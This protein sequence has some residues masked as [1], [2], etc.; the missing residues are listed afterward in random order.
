MSNTFPRVICIGAATLDAIVVADVPLPVDARI[1]VEQ[2]GV[3][4]GGPAATA[5]VA[6]ARQ[7]ISVAFAG[8]VGDDEAG[9]MVVSS[10]E[11]EGVDTRLVQITDGALTAFSAIVVDRATAD[12]L[13]LTRPG[14]LPPVDPRRELLAAVADA[15]WLHL[16]QAGWAVWRAL[17][18]RLRARGSTSGD[19]PLLSVDGGNPIPG[20]EL[21]G[22]ALYAPS[23]AGLRA[24]S[25]KH[26]LDA[27]MRWALDAGAA[28]VVVTRGRSGS[29]AMARFDL[30]RPGAE[31]A[32][33]GGI[34]PDASIQRI[35]EPGHRFEVVSTLGAG[36]VFH[37]LLLAGIREGRSVRDA[38]RR[39]NVGAAVSCRGIDGRSAIPGQ[40]ELETAMR[41]VGTKTASVA[42]GRERRA[43]DAIGAAF[44]TL[45]RPSETFA[46]VAIDQRESLRAMLAA[47]DDPGLILDEALVGF[48]R[49]VMAALGSRASAILL[50]RPLGLP[51]LESLAAP[52]AC[53]LILAADVLDQSPGGPIRR[54]TLDREAPVAAQRIGAVA[55]KML[56]PWRPSESPADRAALVE[57]FTA[58]CRKAG[59]LALVE[60]LVSDDGT[61]S[62]EWNG[63]EGILAAAEEMAG[64]DFDLY[65]A[66]VPT[67]GRGEAQTIR[68]LAARITATIGRPWVVLS[69]GVP[70]E[71]FEHG[72]RAACMGGASGFLAGR[73]IWTSALDAADRLSHLADVSAGRLERLGDL[74]D[75]LGRSWEAAR[76]RDTTYPAR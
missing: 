6:I 36:D 7:G 26:D 21:A 11:R 8:R 31:D 25:G 75:T 44:H 17:A 48:K 46:M 3:A 74:V 38:M 27:A 10:L 5:A 61:R 29:V 22:V 73:A 28:L 20:L 76:S 9:R 13:I 19:G 37:G 45:A 54:V 64:L 70:A 59:L 42:V 51:A 49:E 41:D 60:A 71:R 4:G 67:F 40:V 53:G 55:L 35:E 30:E 56:V 12:R 15:R 32:I 63:T 58:L 2:G 14:L 43:D 23:E 24:A 39:A 66:Q 34:N 57:S 50:D 72:V 68:D 1:A 33:R 62:A 47:D 52:P 65:K 18:G 69:N 16:D